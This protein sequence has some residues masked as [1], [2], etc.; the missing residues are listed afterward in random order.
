VAGDEPALPAICAA[1]DA[2]P[3]AVRRLPPGVHHFQYP[4]AYRCLTRQVRMEPFLPISRL[5]F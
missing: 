4:R 1:I 5:T 3:A 2:L